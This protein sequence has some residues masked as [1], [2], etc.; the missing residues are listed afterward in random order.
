[1]RPPSG[2]LLFYNTLKVLD[3]KK[4]GWSWQKRKDKSGRVRE[5][6]AKLVI[7][8]EITILGTYVHSAEIF[9]FHRRIYY[10]RDC[11]ESIVLVHYFDEANKEPIVGQ[12]AQQSSSNTYITN[13]GFFSMPP[14]PQRSNFLSRDVMPSIQQPA[15][16]KATTYEQSVKPIRKLTSTP[17][18]GSI[19]FRSTDLDDANAIEKTASEFYSD[20][21]FKDLNITVFPADADGLISKQIFQMLDILDFSP[22]WDSINGGAKILICLAAKLCETL[23][24][25]T[26]A[27]FVQFGPNRV[28]AEKITE[29]MLRCTAPE[30]IKIGSVDMFVCIR[31][32]LQECIQVSRKKHFTYRSI[33]QISYSLVSGTAEDKLKFRGEILNFSDDTAPG[34]A[35][36]GKRSRSPTRLLQNLIMKQSEGKLLETSRFLST[37]VESDCKFI[38]LVKVTTSYALPCRLAAIV[39]ERQCKIRVVERLSEFHQAVRDKTTEHR[40]K[41][42]PFSS[43]STGISGER[44]IHSKKLVKSAAPKKN[45]SSNSSTSPTSPESRDQFSLSTKTSALLSSLEASTILDD[46]T[47][48]ALSDNDLEQLSEKLLERLVC[49]LVTVAHTSEELLEELNSLDETGLSLLHY[50]SFYNHSKLVPVLAAHGAHINQQSTQGQTALH[51][52][53]GCGHDKVVNEL[54][55]SGADLQVRD[56][57]GLTAADCAGLSGHIEVAAKLHICIGY[58]VF[59]GEPSATDVSDDIGEIS[60][61][62]DDTLEPYLDAGDMDLLSEIEDSCCEGQT[63]SFDDSIIETSL[64]ITKSYVGENKKYNRKL[65]LRAFSTMSL[66]D[67]CALSLTISRD[68]VSC[69][70]HQRDDSVGEKTITSCSSTTRTLMGSE[71]LPESKVGIEANLVDGQAL[72]S[73]AEIGADVQSVIAE[74]EE[75][76]N[77]LQAAMELMGPEEKQSLEDEVKILQHGIRVWLLKRNCKSM[78][79]TTKQLREATRSVK[80]NKGSRN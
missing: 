16:P 41:D 28:K 4:D 53:A 42:Y 36:N 70:A 67:K 21:L 61:E 45:S 50:V 47:I 1:M 14:N 38:D 64:S 11:Q 77:K 33:R 76:L 56:F 3:Y 9:T 31:G 39:D 7:N 69:G 24:E 34:S 62:M 65:L 71:I 78:R 79:E 68:S 63:H 51:L 48:E 80:T 2:T 60:M 52:A 57:D 72:L 44:S 25:K 6:R 29:S 73:G 15:S 8:R 23:S 17:R 10:L 46:C 74:D 22:S 32:K 37:F 27:F 54:L 30:S 59:G 35:K 20:D 5:D 19:H 13:K 66:H 43:I 26:M 12:L 75:G 49:Q 55:Q 18:S 40:E 58:D